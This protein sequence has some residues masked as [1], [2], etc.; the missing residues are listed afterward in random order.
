MKKRSQLSAQNLKNHKFFDKD[1]VIFDTFYLFRIIS[2]SIITTL[3]LIIYWQFIKLISQQKLNIN[4]QVKSTKITI[5]SNNNF[6][7]QN[8]EQQ[9]VTKSPSILSS[10]ALNTEKLVYNVKQKPQ[11]K[12][13]Q[14]LQKIVDQVVNIASNKSLPT[15]SLSITLIDLK[16]GEE[17]SYQQENPRYP[18]SVVKLYW[19]VMLQSQLEQKNT[20]EDKSL[21][22]ELE[23]MIKKS[24]NEAA[25]RILD[26][27]TKTESGSNLNSEELENWLDKREQV[28]QF[29]IN[30]GYEN[31]NI[32]QKTFPIPYLKLYSPQR[33]DLQ[34][35]KDINQ[36]IRNKIT[37]KET[38]Q[39]MY[40]IVNQ[41]AV[42]PDKSKKMLD[43]LSIDTATRIN[44]RY[45]KNP[46]T[47]NSVRGFFSQSLPDDVDF[48]AKA[49]W[50]SELRGETAY[51]A[52]KDRKTQYILTI[53]A[54]DPSYAYNW[55]I[56]PEISQLVFEQMKNRK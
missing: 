4:N 54:E 40:E 47:F 26:R 35:R 1:I 51:I 55:D 48:A 5:N 20:I 21:S 18:A 53:L 8:H 46:N 38:S 45:D 2:I 28:N 31:L 23:K 27:I 22:L 44:K 34:M 13:S 43:L 50:T 33:R 42:S 12:N 39:L 29:F 10:E 49:G 24:D 11:L 52:T 32:S 25:S 37:T 14:D 41:Q 30:A 56:F 7:P 3:I 15:T 9:V 16:T 6:E 17:A 36:P 19:L